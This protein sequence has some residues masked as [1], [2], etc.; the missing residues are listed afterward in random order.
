[1]RHERSSRQISETGYAPAVVPQEALAPALEALDECDAILGKLDAGCCDPGRSPRMTS[2]AATLAD[3][4][5][6]LHRLTVDSVLTE[7]TLTTLEDAGSQVGRLQVGCCAPK[8]LPLYADML[9]R[10]TA[11]QLTINRALGADH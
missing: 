4:R 5:A 7:V 3:A 6:G 10:L 9:E 2:L 11:A 1:M 8:R